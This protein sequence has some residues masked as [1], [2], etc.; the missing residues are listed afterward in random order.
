[1]PRTKKPE[2]RLPIKLTWRQRKMLAYADPG[3]GDRLKLDEPNQRIIE[4]TVAEL[5]AIKVKA[6]AAIQ[7]ASTGYARRPLC[8]VL[9]ATDQA[10]TQCRTRQHPHVCS[11][12]PNP[13]QQGF[14]LDEDPAK[15]VPAH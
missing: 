6:E 11:P 4:L 10:I 3:L 8:L 5:K 12:E 15:E 14:D 2:L 9:K 1:M 13:L 7:K